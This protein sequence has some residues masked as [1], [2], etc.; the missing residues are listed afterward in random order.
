MYS[1]NED[2][3]WLVFRASGGRAN[4]FADRSRIRRKCCR[5]RLGAEGNLDGLGRHILSELDAVHGLWIDCGEVG[6]LLASSDSPRL[7]VF[8]VRALDQ[9]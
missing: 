5:L 7:H 2:R 3:R 9:G 4:S 6:G 8:A 1:T